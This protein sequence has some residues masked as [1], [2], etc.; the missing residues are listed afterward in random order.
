[1]AVA[2]A[3]ALAGLGVLMPM[4]EHGRYDMAFAVGD[5]ILK[6]QCKCATRKGDCLVVRLV[7]SRRCAEGYKRTRYW[8]NEIDLVAAYSDE[9]DECYLIA[10]EEIEGMTAF[11]MRLTPAR[12]NQQ[13]AINF[14]ADYEFTG[15]VAQLEERVHGMHEV[16]GSSPLSS[17]S[18]SSSTPTTVGA[19]EFGYRYARFLQRA[20][21]GEEFVVTRRG[22]PMARISPP[23]LPQQL[24]LVPADGA[25]TR[26]AVGRRRSRDP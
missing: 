5:R 18:G 9:L 26:L 6:V 21:G 16:R 19:E 13:A 14:A 4:T 24:D 23:E 3:A 15:A 22:R 12:N 10:I 7:A 17:I 1:M 2:K 20:A 25:P 8:R 11:Q